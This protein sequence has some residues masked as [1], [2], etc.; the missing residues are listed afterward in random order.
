MRHLFRDWSRVSFKIQKSPYV[1][2]FFDYDGTLTP[3]VSR[4][5]LARFPRTVKGLIKRLQRDPKFIVSIISGRS[6]KN[7]KEMVGLKGI[8]YVGNHGLEIEGR[9]IK[10]SKRISLGS[11]G[12]LIKRIATSLGREFKGI[13]GVIL[14]NKG[15]TLS[16][17]YRLAA[18]RTLP[19]IKKKF[20]RIVN[21]YLYSRKVK[22]SHGKKVLEV[23]PNLDWDKGETVKWLL[24]RKKRALPLYLGDD[25]TDMDA[26]R[27]IKGKGISI[28]VG[29]PKRGIRADYFLRNPKDVKKFIERL[30]KLYT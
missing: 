20:Y 30:L 8:I 28:F 11:F 25:V 9:G 1:F 17:H 16:V 26:F 5:G 27:A 13:R 19:S 12:P 24:K 3:I 6:L 2:L 15:A 10:S 4:P 23:R 14:E 21:P 22:I 7:I 29:S 18:P